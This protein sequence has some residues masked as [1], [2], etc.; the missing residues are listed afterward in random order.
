MDGN[1]AA[2]VNHLLKLARI[3]DDDREKCGDFGG[4]DCGEEDDAAN[5]AAEEYWKDDYHLTIHNCAQI[6]EAMF[7]TINELRE[8]EDQ[9]RFDNEHYEPNMIFFINRALGAENVTIE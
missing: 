9:I 4:I 5:K 2:W 1:C 6:G 8:L 3:Y 7:E